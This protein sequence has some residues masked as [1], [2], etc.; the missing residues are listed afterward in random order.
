MQDVIEPQAQALIT[1][2]DPYTEALADIAIQIQ[3]LTTAF[4]ELDNLHGQEKE[5]SSAC[6]EIVTEEKAIL[7]NPNGSEKQ[8][9]DKLVRIRA[10]RDIRNAKLAN[11]RKQIGQHVDLLIYDLGQPLRQSLSN[12]ANSLPYPPHATDPGVVR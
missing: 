10:T 11:M 8:A 1:E 4:V 12:L 9:V 6:D 7:E 3:Q 5:L 2:T